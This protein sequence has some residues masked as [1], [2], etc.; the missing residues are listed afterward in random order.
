[1]KIVLLLIITLSLWSTTVSAQSL[2]KKQIDKLSYGTAVQFYTQLM[3]FADPEICIKGLQDGFYPDTAILNHLNHLDDSLRRKDNDLVTRADKDQMHYARAYD[4]MA[5]W[6]RYKKLPS[7]HFDFKVMAE[8]LHDMNNYEDLR[9]NDIE[10][11]NVYQA[12]FVP[13]KHEHFKKT[14]SKTYRHDLSYDYGVYMGNVAKEYGF[15]V[16]ERYVKLLVKGIEESFSIDTL[17]GFREMYNNNYPKNR[18]AGS[19]N[20]FY[21]ISNMASEPTEEELSFYWDTLYYSIGLSSG[22]GRYAQFC[23]MTYYKQDFDFDVLT[24]GALDHL[25]DTTEAPFFFKETPLLKDYFSRFDEPFGQ[26]RKA[27]EKHFQSIS[28][29]ELIAPY[30][31]AYGVLF[32]KKFEEVPSK[33]HQKIMASFEK[34]FSILKDFN[35]TKEADLIFDQ[36][37]GIDIA[38]MNVEQLSQWAYAFGISNYLTVDFFNGAQY[39][40]TF[41]M[42]GFKAVL[43]KEKMAY[44][45]EKMLEAT[46][47][48]METLDEKYTSR[49]AARKKLGY[50][51]AISMADSLSKFNFTKEEHDVNKILEGIEFS[52]KIDS[53]AYKKALE[54]IMK[55]IDSK[56]ASKTKTKAAEVAF[57]FGITSI[58]GQFSQAGVYPFYP[59]LSFPSFRNG[60][61]DFLAKKTLMMTIE[62]ANNIVYTK[63]DDYK[64]MY[65]EVFRLKKKRDNAKQYAPIIKASKV[66]IKEQ[67]QRKEVVQYDGVFY[68]EVLKK[69]ESDRHPTSRSDTVTIICKTMLYDGKAFEEPN[70][71][72]DTII[73]I[74][75]HTFDIGNLQLAIQ[76]M[77]VGSKYRFYIGSKQAYYLEGLEGQV[78][79][80]AAVVYEIEL[81]D[82]RKD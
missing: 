81:L 9:Y 60:Y 11:I 49:M 1:M 3:E 65:A 48:D 56:E 8:A 52:S 24:Q 20:K 30:L 10:C 53:T 32:A 36:L 38:T 5:K 39:E 54:L 45:K 51:F 76:K 75:I 66:F 26:Y 34:G 68:Y 67:T 70:L 57:S 40:T 23:D 18:W 2:S 14:W 61:R 15:P 27:Y 31:Y 82:V 35:A 71:P 44:T 63:I 22:I 59:E 73:T 37:N 29:N 79:P 46:W 17:N 41:I 25:R 74:A 28:E 47:E 72:S 62:E 6:A 33:N 12:Y 55:R 4:F 16:E 19:V 43:N 78:P 50:A 7:N 13:I 58:F 21:A 77:T 64:S 80:G 69:G 42:K